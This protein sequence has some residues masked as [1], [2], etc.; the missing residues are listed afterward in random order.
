MKRVKIKTIADVRSKEYSEFELVEFAHG[1]YDYDNIEPYEIE[2]DTAR[3]SGRTEYDGDAMS[4][5]E[6]RTIIDELE[7]YGCTHVGIKHDSTNKKHIFTGCEVTVSSEEELAEIKQK[8]KARAEAEKAELEAK[9]AEV[10][11]K[12]TKLQ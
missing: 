5:A 4:L 9:L 7:G 2:L 3:S 8:K 10:N 6:V 1:E 11:S 12:L